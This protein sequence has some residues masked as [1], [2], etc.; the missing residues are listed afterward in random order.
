[1][2]GIVEFSYYEQKKAGAISDF[3][4]LIDQVHNDGYSSIVISYN[5]LD[6]IDVGK[7]KE[8][9]SYS[10]E[11]MVD[12]QVAVD[13]TLQWS[14]SVGKMK[15][16]F[17]CC[18]Y[19]DCKILNGVFDSVFLRYRQ[20]LTKRNMIERMKKL[21]ERLDEIATMASEYNIKVALENH[22]D[23][24]TDEIKSI[25]TNIGKENLGICFDT[26]NQLLI[27]EIPEESVI[28][29]MPW[30][31]CTHIK[32]AKVDSRTDSALQLVWS[33]ISEGLIDCEYIIKVISQ[34]KLDSVVK[35]NIEV[36][37]DQKLP[38]IPLGNSGFWNNHFSCTNT[39]EKFLNYLSKKQHKNEVNNSMLVGTNYLHERNQVLDARKWFDAIRN[40]D[41]GLK[42]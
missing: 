22:I 21:E 34:N 24:T 2:I 16:V 32:N 12:I 4:D 35:N 42:R 17:E 38:S 25:L 10:K 41:S 14:M 7:R 36:I 15:N 8:Y 27:G 13:E 26:G 29:L 6:N 3:F 9:K 1:M 20:D 5:T 39:I 40:K 11:K 18:A 31:M 33:D 23:Y 19:Y 30:I 28:Q 37:I